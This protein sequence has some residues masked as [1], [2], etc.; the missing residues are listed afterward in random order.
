VANLPN[1]QSSSFL[2]TATSSGTVT[3]TAKYRVDGNTATFLSHSI[4]VQ[5]FG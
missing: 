2:F 3:F 4:T 1:G 5:V